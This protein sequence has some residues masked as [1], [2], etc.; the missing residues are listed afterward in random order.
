MGSLTVHVDSLPNKTSV[1]IIDGGFC[2]TQ[3]KPESVQVTYDNDPCYKVSNARA[4]VTNNTFG[5]VWNAD[6]ICSAP[7]RGLYEAL[8]L[9]SLTC[10]AVY[11]L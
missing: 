7:S 4:Q 9:L 3:P 10:L 11:L 6:F 5:A 8:T 2:G 1:E